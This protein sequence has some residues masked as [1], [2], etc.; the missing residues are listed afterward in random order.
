MVGQRHPEIGGDQ[1]DHADDQGPRDIAAGVADLLGDRRDVGPAVV[2]PQDADHRGHHA[3]EDRRGALGRRPE[4][5]EIGHRPGAEQEWQG[6]EGRDAADLQRR[7]DHLER[8]PAS[9]TQDVDDRHHGDGQHGGTGLPDLDAGWPSVARPRARSTGRTPRPGSPSSRC[10]RP[11]TRPSRT[12]T[13][14]R[15]RRPRGGRRTGRRPAAASPPARP[16]SAPRPAEDPADDPDQHDPA[17]ERHVVGHLRRDQED[18][19]ADH[20]SDDGGER[21]ERAQHPR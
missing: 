5:R 19:R 12:G 8:A 18:P 9:R 20:R 14:A 15:T 17:H 11:G 21:G 3:L 16:A 13:P 1:H 10:G 2:G 7:A 6:D 4:R